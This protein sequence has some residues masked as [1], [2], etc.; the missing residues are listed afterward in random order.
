MCLH[1][2]LYFKTVIII[3]TQRLAITVPY[4]FCQERL[5]LASLASVSPVCQLSRFY[6]QGLMLQWIL[7]A[8]G[9]LL[10]KVTSQW[11]QEN[12]AFCSQKGDSSARDYRREGEPHRVSCSMHLTIGLYGMMS[13]NIG[14]RMLHPK[15]FEKMLMQTQ[16]IGFLCAKK[17]LSLTCSSWLQ[18]NRGYPVLL[19]NVSAGLFPQNSLWV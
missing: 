1:L 8:S 11:A 7:Q 5:Q 12:L 18:Q 9:N 15:M 10:Q 3:V 19:G 16:V 2:S 13:A 14:E 17:P 6:Q 4:Q